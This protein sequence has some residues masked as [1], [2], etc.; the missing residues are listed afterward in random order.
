MVSLVALDVRKRKTRWV[1]VSRG[2]ARSGRSALPPTVC[3][4]RGFRS[5]GIINTQLDDPSA[6]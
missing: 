2:S 1:S 6:E 3:A 5:A 4:C